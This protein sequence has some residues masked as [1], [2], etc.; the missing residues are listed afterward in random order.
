MPPP[1]SDMNPHVSARA[2]AT[3]FGNRRYNRSI[4]YIRAQV[5]A[6][7]CNDCNVL[8]YFC[9]SR[10]TAREV[11][12]Q[13]VDGAVQ[14]F[15]VLAKTKTREVARRT[16]RLIVEGAD[17]HSGDAGFDGDVAAEI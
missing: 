10:S 2:A 9:P 3:R 13:S 15:V 4:K 12:S 11:S 16:R 1:A 14:S 8:P 5:G 6:A 17:R 7:N